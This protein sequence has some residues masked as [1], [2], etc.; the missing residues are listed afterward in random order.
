MFF[1]QSYPA[2]CD[3]SHGDASSEGHRTGYGIIY[4]DAGVYVRVQ[5][6]HVRG[7]FVT[8]SLADQVY[9]ANDGCAATEELSVQTFLLEHSPLVR[10]HVKTQGLATEQVQGTVKLRGNQVI[11]KEE[12]ILG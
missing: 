10:L 7:C 3:H 1:I 2:S 5:Q 4:L 11:S 6:H 8:F 9:L 12:F